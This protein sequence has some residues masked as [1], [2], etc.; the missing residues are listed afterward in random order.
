MVGRLGSSSK[1]ISWRTDKGNA[2]IS[3]FSW[4]SCSIAAVSPC[5][6]RF[7]S[8]MEISATSGFLENEISAPVSASSS[9]SWSSLC[10]FNGNTAMTGKL[11]ESRYQ[12][13]GQ[14]V[15]FALQ[16]HLEYL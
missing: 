5:N 16:G 13:G 1:L 10:R 11:E 6:L 4:V 2:A 7:S 3:G 14:S 9:I 12:Q 8:S 15:C